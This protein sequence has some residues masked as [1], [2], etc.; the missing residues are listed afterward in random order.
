MLREVAEYPNCFGPHRAPGPRK[1]IETPALHAL[2]RARARPGT[3]SSGSASRLTSSTTCSRRSAATCASAGGRRRSGR[4]ARRRPPGLVDALLARGVRPD[5]DPYAVALVLTSEPPAMRPG[6]TARRSRD[7]RGARGRLRGQWE[8]FGSSAGGN[9][10][11]EDASCTALPRER[12]PAARGLA[13]RRDR[14]HRHGVADRARLLLYGGATAERARGRGAYRALIR[15]AGT[16]PSGS[17]TPALI[18]QGGSMIP[19]DPGAP[20]LRARRRGAHAAGRLRRRL[21]AQANT[22]TRYVDIPETAIHH[23]SETGR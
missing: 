7:D 2:P 17:G 16:T 13:R 8:A 12:D 4:S 20:R 5:K 15:A 6:F 1:R 14:L 3:P 23:D 18:T 21:I 11:G 9:R 10:R 22:S 19:A